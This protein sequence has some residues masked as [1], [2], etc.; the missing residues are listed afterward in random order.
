MEE[1]KQYLGTD[2]LAAW[3]SEEKTAE[4]LDDFNNWVAVATKGRQGI[5]IPESLSLPITME[6]LVNNW[7]AVMKLHP[8][9]VGNSRH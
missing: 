3:P 5:S 8:A 7:E 1:A 2:T 9:F 4:V 6:D